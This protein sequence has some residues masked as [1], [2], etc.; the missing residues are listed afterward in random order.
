SATAAATSEQNAADSATAAATSEQNAADSATAAATSEQNAADYAASVDPSNIWHKNENV[1]ADTVDGYHV[2]A[3]KLPITGLL[4]AN[5]YGIG[6]YGAYYTETNLDNYPVGSIGLVTPLTNILINSPV[7][8]AFRAVVTTLGYDLYIIQEL[9]D[10]NGTVYRRR[11]YNGTW[12]AWSKSWTDANDGVDSDLDAGLLGGYGSADYIRFAQVTGAYGNLSAPLTHLPLKKNL[13]TAQGQSICTFTRASAATYV[14]RYGVLRTASA[15][16]PRFTADGLLLEGASTNLLTYSEQFDNAVWMKLRSSVSANATETTD[17]YGTNLADKLIEDTTATITHLVSQLYSFTAGTTYTFS[18]Y[19]KAG[20]RSQM[21]LRFGD[22][23]L[24][25]GFDLSSGTVLSAS[26]GVTT[27]I[28]ALANGWY[29]VSATETAVNSGSYAAQIQ[30]MV[31]GV[32]SYTGDGTSGIYIFGAQ[33]EAM[34][35]ATSYIPTTTT[36]ATRAADTCYVPAVE[37]IPAANTSDSSIICDVKLSG[38]NNS[39]SSQTVWRLNDS[40]RY[41]RNYTVDNTWQY[42]EGSSN[43]SGGSSSTSKKRISTTFSTSSMKIYLDGISVSSTTPSKSVTGTATAMYIGSS[44]GT[45]QFLFGT[46]SNL[47]IYDRALTEKEV[48]WA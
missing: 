4:K 10:V 47:R 25:A 6:S 40:F 26:S 32:T 36:S 28:T 27:K 2:E 42:V 31:S 1:N 3:T 20:S 14:D 44:G 8:S 15:D 11:L 7:S 37:N 23:G 12:G 38:L 18:V 33:F 13:L 22:S 9:I 29:R 19:A 30:L 41:A 46:I 21:A 16:T 17:P 39:A 35:F 43:I 5:D 48:R 34:P 45:E 24:A